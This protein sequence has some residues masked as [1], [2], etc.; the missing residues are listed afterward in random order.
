M[1]TDYIQQQQACEQAR[2]REKSV[3]L[4]TRNYDVVNNRYLNDLALVTD[5]IDAGNSL[6]A[7]E[8]MLVNARV[9]VIYNHYKL[10]RV[11]GT[12]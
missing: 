10:Q 9:N 2:T 3:E 5:M 8:L 11:S 6:L 7:A 12:L 1:N 4:A